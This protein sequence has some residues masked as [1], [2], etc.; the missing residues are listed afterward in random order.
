[1]FQ[2]EKKTERGW[3]KVGNPFSSSLEA[4]LAR[5]EWLPGVWTRIEHVEPEN[6]KPT[7]KE[8]K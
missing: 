3:E 7:G 2:I 6:A 5:R 8:A 4:E 1:M